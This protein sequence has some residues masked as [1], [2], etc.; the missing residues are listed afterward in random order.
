MHAETHH[1]R[2]IILA[3][4]LSLLA[5]VLLPRPARSGWSADPVQVHATSAFCPLV[6]ASDDAH[7]GAVVVWQE[8]T[9]SG[10]L[11]RAQHVLAN[12]DLDAGWGGPVAVSNL[13]ITRNAI[14]AVSD[15]AGGAYVWWMEG[16]QLWLQHLSS[17][18]G[19]ATGWLARG[20]NLG[21]LATSFHRPLVVADGRGGV[22]V[23]WLTFAVFTLPATAS[24][25]VVHLGPT[26]AGAGGWPGGGRPFGFGTGNNPSVFSFGMDAAP[27]SGLWLAWQTL[28][29]EN[30]GLYLP[31]DFRVLR[32]TSAGLPAAGWTATGVL[33]APFDPG[34]LAS[35]PGWLQIAFSGQV[36]VANDGGVG[37]YV[38][39]AQ[40]MIEQGDLVFHNSLRHVDGTGASAAGWNTNGV[41]LGDLFATG[42][43]DPGEQASLRAIADG[44]GGVFSGLPTFGSESFAALVLTH[45]D[46]AGGTLPGGLQASQQ[47]LELASRDDGGLFAADFKPSGASSPFDGDAFIRVTESGPGVGFFETKRSFTATRYGDLGLTSTRDGGAIFAWSQLIDRQGVFAVRLNPDGV[48]TSVPPPAPVQGQPSLRLRFVPGVG[49][50]AL[51]ASVPAGAEVLTLHDV[52]GRLIARTSVDQ[53]AGGDWL[54]PGTEGLP[55]GLYFARSLSGG[56]NLH[57]RV[58]VVR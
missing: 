13:D 5:L 36:A 6:S 2:T 28:D 44:H 31:G 45:F 30:S 56:M 32:T 3:L 1:T 23:G 19:P 15:G 10:G 12:G 58:A 33:L 14:G 50:R 55:S 37:S 25:R 54:F 48:V 8:N 26:G 35:S 39:A 9:A 11:L 17:A 4:L 43:P 7:F 24:I 41:D 29:I 22:Y 46:A 27:D 49:V 57:A 18:G 42:M 40:G 52:T 16:E 53:A 38:V 51:L 20:R 47:G 34:F 21:T